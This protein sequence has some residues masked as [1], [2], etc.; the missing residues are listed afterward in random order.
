MTQY[1]AGIGQATPALV[2]WFLI[3]REVSLPLN[4]RNINLARIGEG[5]EW[6]PAMDADV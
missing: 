6:H 5:K 3:M 2:L 1:I 4:R